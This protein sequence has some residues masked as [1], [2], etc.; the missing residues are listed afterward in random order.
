MAPPETLA[1]RCG[2]FP[3]PLTRSL[4]TSSG[5]SVPQALLADPT[6]LSPAPSPHGPVLPSEPVGSGT[7]YLL[8]AQ[9]R[10]AGLWKKPVW[11]SGP[12]G[13]RGGQS[14]KGEQQSHSCRPAVGATSPGQV[15]LCNRRLILPPPSQCS[16]SNGVMRNV[17]CTGTTMAG[18]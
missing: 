4:C 13:R 7:P 9:P 15:R 18:K 14:A 12:G 3:Q 16:A 1:W 5:I 8:G 10:R 17:G 11:K 6:R 2:S